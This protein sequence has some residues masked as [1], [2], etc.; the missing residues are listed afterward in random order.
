MSSRPSPT[1]DPA[2]LPA[3]RPTPD[4]PGSRY[5]HLDLEDGSTIIYDPE[6]TDTWLQSDYVVELGT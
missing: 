1:D 3:R 2:D 5:V 6:G 4:G